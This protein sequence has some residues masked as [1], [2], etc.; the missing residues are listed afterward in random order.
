MLKHYKMTFTLNHETFKSLVIPAKTL[1][2]AY[3]EI[4]TRF[5][6]VAITEAIESN[7]VS[8]GWA[9]SIAK[10]MIANASLDDTCTFASYLDEEKRE[11]LVDAIWDEWHKYM[12]TKAV[13]K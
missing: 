7:K 13:Q 4:Q 8:D 6:G 9:Q 3:I 2:D 1:V 11:E 5:P 12:H 10:Y